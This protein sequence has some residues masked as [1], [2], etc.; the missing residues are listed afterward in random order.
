MDFNTKT[1]L[2][3]RSL[4]R[5]IAGLAEGEEDGETSRCGVCRKPKRKMRM[6]TT[7]GK[8]ATTA[9]SGTMCYVLCIP[10]GHEV[11]N[12]NDNSD[13]NDVPLYWKCHICS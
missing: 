13:E 3:K 12:G 6:I 5:I 1:I 11:P 8:S 10:A 7:V 4:I 9:S 2:T